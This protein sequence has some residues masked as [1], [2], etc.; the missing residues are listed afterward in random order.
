[1]SEASPARIDKTGGPARA[2]RLR[3][4]TLVVIRW[5]A[6]MGQAAAV[7]FVHL[8]LGFDLPLAPVGATIFAAALSNVIMAMT[9]PAQARLSD[10]DGAIYLAFDILQLSLLLFLTGGVQ[11][12]FAILLMAPVTIAAATLSGSSTVA[13]VGLTVAAIACL[14]AYHLRL[15]W[16]GEA[17]EMPGIYQAGIGVALTVATLFIA[18]YAWSLSNAQRRMLDA[19]AATQA[20]LAREQRLSALGGLAAAAAHELG[21]P[22]STIAVVAQ[23]L[24]RAVSP[25]D[26]LSEDIALLVSQS[27]RCRDI[28][29]RL[30]ERPEQSGGAPFELLPASALVEAAAQAATAAPPGVATRLAAAA[31]DGSGEPLL[32]RAPEILHAL[33]NLVENARQFAR[34][35]VTVETRWSADELTVTVADDGPGF[36][37][38]ILGELGE[39]Y[40]TNRRGGGHMGLGV[41]IAKTLLERTG[42]T[43]VFANQASGGAEVAIRWRRA[44]IEATGA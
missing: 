32:A 6:V 39:P 2:G 37:I 27:Q 20:A 16:A 17:V 5:V 15:P 28:L 8:G 21:S 14:G 31:S 33:G 42:A 3:L 26:P 41:F 29:A 22:L 10:R 30:A 24:R 19:L 12:P 4:R 18:V 25:D 44:D 9:R 11:N 36:A 40:L 23:E 35:A 43:L 38:D 34:T 7:L 13:L 1:M